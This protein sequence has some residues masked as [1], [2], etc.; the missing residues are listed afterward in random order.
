MF[1]SASED[2]SLLG[3]HTTHQRINEGQSNT[4]GRRPLSSAGLQSHAGRKN[5]RS[6]ASEPSRLTEDVLASFNTWAFKREQPSDVGLMASTVSRA[7]ARYEPVPFVLYWGK[8]PRTQLDEPDTICLDYLGKMAERVRR[9]YAPGIAFRLIFTDSHAELNGHS[10]T[11]AKLYFDA[12]AA[13]AHMRGHTTCNLSD[14]VAAARAYTAEEPS[15]TPS[16]DVRADLIAC[17]AKWYR[18]GGSIEQGALEYYRI[19]MAEKRAVEIAFPE[20]VFVTFNGADFRDLFPDRMPIFFM[21]SLRRG[22]GVKPWFISRAAT[23]PT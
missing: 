5:A 13:A 6:P 2:S 1:H 22:V 12:V 7:I 14:V 10:A 23:A 8:G 21:Y 20:A 11:A 19:N 3:K 15:E 18:G 4:V 16:D 17:A 9:V